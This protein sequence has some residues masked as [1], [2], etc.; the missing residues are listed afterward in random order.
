MPGAGPQSCADH[1]DKVHSPDTDGGEAQGGT[2]E[3]HIV[4]PSSR[5]CSLAETEE[6]SVGAENRDDNGEDEQ[7]RLRS[8]GD[9]V[10]RVPLDEGL[11]V[12]DGESAGHRLRSSSRL[13]LGGSDSPSKI[14]D[15]G[16][17][18]IRARFLLSV[19]EDS[20]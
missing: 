9:R 20:R 15:G 7:T 2:A 17:M 19:D 1:T 6:G 13:R 5:S 11:G 10:L 14:F 16:A 18:L 12:W 4:A 3:E 8:Q